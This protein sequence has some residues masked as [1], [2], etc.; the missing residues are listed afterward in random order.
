MKTKQIER[1][2]QITIKAVKGLLEVAQ[3]E[4]HENKIRAYRIKKELQIHAFK[5]E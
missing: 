1:P 4:K 3:K 2:K 5:R